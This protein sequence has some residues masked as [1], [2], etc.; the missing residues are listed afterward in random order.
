MYVKIMTYFTV[1]WPFT[2]NCFYIHKQYNLLML[3]HQDQLDRMLRFV[4]MDSPQ[5]NSLIVFIIVYVLFVELIAI[6]KF[7]LFHGDN[8][9]SLSHP[10]IFPLSSWWIIH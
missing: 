1:K 3:V 7:T 6:Q 2:L 10:P 8:Y 4:I 9:Y 5:N